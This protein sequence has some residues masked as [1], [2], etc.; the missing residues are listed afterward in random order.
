MEWFGGLPAFS[1]IGPPGPQPEASERE[2]NQNST[3]G[4]DMMDHA[5]GTRR[6]MMAA[7]VAAAG[8]GGLLALQTEEEDS[9]P[10]P[11]Q[12]VKIAEF[13]R[14]GECEGV[15]QVSPV[16][17]PDA[18]WKRRLPVDQYMVTRRGDTEFAFTGEFWN[19]EGDG[20]YRCVCCDTAL[21]DSK[22]KY[23]SGTGWPS[24]WAPVAKENIVER[25]DNSFAMRRVEV[26]CARCGA[27]LGHIF[28]DGPPPT[29]QRYCLNSVALKFV[30][31]G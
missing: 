11:G 17:F 9:G 2:D 19:F 10:A 4:F 1:L 15:R 28:D 12:K 6:A 21:F 27:H 8:F 23:S 13:A 26:V 31:R 29:N 30:P 22:T 14:N 7:L 3:V 16:Y 20:L 5:E 24:F 25:W 18:E